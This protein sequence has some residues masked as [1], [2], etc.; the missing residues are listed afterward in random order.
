MNADSH[1]S[2]KPSLLENFGKLDSMSLKQNFPIKKSLTPSNISKANKSSLIL[3][4]PD[5]PSSGFDWS[6]NKPW[7]PFEAPQSPILAAGSDEDI[8]WCMENDQPETLKLEEK[9]NFHSPNGHV[10]KYQTTG[11]GDIRQQL[12]VQ[13]T[14][15]A[16]DDHSEPKTS[17]PM[18]KVRV[19]TTNSGSSTVTVSPSSGSMRLCGHNLDSGDTFLNQHRP[20]MSS[21]FMSPSARATLGTHDI[22]TVFKTPNRNQRN[23]DDIQ[24]ATPSRNGTPLHLSPASY[25]FT[26]GRQFVNPFEID[27]DRLHMPIFSPNLFKVTGAANKESNKTEAFWSVE[28]TA[29]LMPVDIKDYEIRRQHVFQQKL[30][31][32][33]DAKIQ[34][35]INTFFSNEVIVPSPWTDKVNHVLPRTPGMVKSV[36][37]QTAM[38]VPPNVDLFAE[39]D[40]KYLLPESRTET[41]PA[42]DSIANSFIRRKLLHQLN[43]N[44]SNQCSPSRPPEE[45]SSSPSSGKQTT[46]EWEKGSSNR[47]F[48]SSPIELSPHSRGHHLALSE[49][50]LLASPELFPAGGRASKTLRSS[51]IYFPHQDVDNAQTVMH[52]DFSSI[53]DDPDEAVQENTGTVTQKGLNDTNQTA[54]AFAYTEN[55]SFA[56]SHDSEMTTNRSGGFSRK[57]LLTSV[58]STESGNDVVSAPQASSSQDTGY[59]TAS[60]QS[61]RHD[62]GS[63]SNLVYFDSQPTVPFHSLEEADPSNSEKLFPTQSI[64]SELFTTVRSKIE[65]ARNFD[66][67]FLGLGRWSSQEKSSSADDIVLL[68]RNE[69]CK[70]RKV[71]TLADIRQSKVS[72][73]LTRSF[74]EEM[75]KS[76][77]NRMPDSP[78]HLQNKVLGAINFDKKPTLMRE[79]NKPSTE[80]HA[81]RENKTL[82]AS[83]ISDVS[84]RSVS[85]YFNTSSEKNDSNSQG[86]EEKQF[87]DHSTPCKQKFQKYSAF[88]DDTLLAARM[89]LEKTIDMPEKLTVDEASRLDCFGLFQDVENQDPLQCDSARSGM[90]SYLSDPSNTSTPTSRIFNSLE[91]KINQVEGSKLGSEIAAEIIKRAETDLAELTNLIGKSSPRT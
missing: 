41:S 35:A 78:Q 11:P 48:S 89:L 6:P 69:P 87:L 72:R 7:H 22:Q 47:Q 75:E 86:F 21:P 28:H 31:K 18:R 32:E 52:L 39:L 55:M 58:T 82:D 20:Y 24:V 84:M 88:H 56:T 8:N 77:M 76:D 68:R 4:F 17:S 45:V 38:S 59:Q 15:N 51:E 34:S 50:D 80:P 27:H 23:H 83:D 29:A 73:D 53:L 85:P 16:H 70:I 43:D 1:P 54:E 42:A 65:S 60:L 71:R 74:N 61:T 10:F 19:C 63:N 30:D 62:C 44:D 14:F 2:T 81:L 13:R 12:L 90:T 9:D 91:K 33:Q 37:C 66:G 57:S 64:P 67:S 25:N 5:T 26:P 3:K 79:V 46:P 36:S 49:T 40:G